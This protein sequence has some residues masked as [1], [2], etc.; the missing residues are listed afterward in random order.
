MGD[1]EVMDSCTIQGTA[2]GKRKRGSGTAALQNSQYSLQT[3]LIEK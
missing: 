3:I 2:A 1:P